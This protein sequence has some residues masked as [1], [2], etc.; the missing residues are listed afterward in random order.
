M[1]LLPG[2]QERLREEYEQCPYLANYNLPVCPPKIW[3]C[4]PSP[5]RAYAFPPRIN[6]EINPEIS[7]CSKIQEQFL[8]KTCC[9]ELP[10]THIYCYD[11]E[12]NTR[13][14]HGVVRVYIGANYVACKIEYCCIKYLINQTNLTL[15]EPQ[16]RFGDKLLELKQLMTNYNNFHSAS[17]SIKNNCLTRYL[18]CNMKLFLTVRWLMIRRAGWSYFLP[19][20]Y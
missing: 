15:L 6:Y 14:E 4:S 5:M 13:I 12:W 3:M 11:D 18:V 20:I 8:C 2:V 19:G 7:I 10:T 1:S 16:S 9:H 17:T